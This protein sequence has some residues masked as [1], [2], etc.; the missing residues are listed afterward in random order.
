[1]IGQPHKS[2]SIPPK[3]LWPVLI[4]VILGLAV[5][6]FFL[7]NSYIYNEKQGDD[8]NV[9]VKDQGNEDTNRLEVTNSNL[10]PD[11]YHL[12]NKE[13]GYSVDYPKI[14]NAQFGSTSDHQV[15]LHSDD[16]LNTIIIWATSTTDEE[17]PETLEIAS[18][19]Q[20]TEDFS[21]AGVVG[22]K[23][24]YK[25]CDGPGCSPDIVSV[26]I[27]LN[28]IHYSIR[29]YGDKVIDSDEQS[30]ID[31][32]TVLNIADTSNW[33]AFYNVVFGYSFN[34]PADKKL[35]GNFFTYSPEHDTEVYVGHNDIGTT[36]LYIHVNIPDGYI[37]EVKQELQKPLAEYAH[38]VWQLNSEDNNPYKEM[39]DLATIQV[40]EY[41]A[42]T[43][44][45]TKSLSPSKGSGFSLPVKSQIVMLEDGVNKL[46]AVIPETSE[47]GLEILD[48][49]KLALRADTANWSS[50]RNDEYGYTI[51]HPEDWSVSA[52]EYVEGQTNIIGPSVGEGPFQTP[53]VNIGLKDDLY[54]DDFCLMKDGT[55]VVNK[56]QRRQQE[57]GCSLAGSTVSTFFPYEG[58]NLTV[59]WTTDVESSFVIYQQIL[60]SFRLL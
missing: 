54:P 15:I 56:T 11:W 58:K 18:F 8:T 33:P 52:S 40:G 23:Y 43:F 34:Y 47:Y 7:L 55:V 32:F 41:S 36:D 27:I 53:Y 26:D 29:L 2:P 42:Y 21:F 59:S 10:Y 50:Y 45:T 9:V 22:K 19:P 44:T 13:S 24:T 14:Y 12:I 57:E 39:S 38:Y 48:T 60:E 16:D 51:Q 4:V 30:I 3:V 46:L 17:L 35:F 5:G 25:I 28:A 49:I 20:P 31:S 1:M 6:G 37:D